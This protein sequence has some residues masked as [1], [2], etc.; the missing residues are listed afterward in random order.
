MSC[1]SGCDGM[2]GGEDGM[3]GSYESLR[4][5]RAS[6]RALALPC[7]AAAVAPVLYSALH[8]LRKLCL[9][10]LCKAV[11]ARASVLYSA[12]HRRCFTALLRQLRAC[13]AG[14]WLVARRSA[15]VKQR[16]V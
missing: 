15:C 12:L 1:G 14:G 4:Y 9:H 5:T 16:L 11:K 6:T 13:V 2:S 3:A 8:S 10:S 7:L